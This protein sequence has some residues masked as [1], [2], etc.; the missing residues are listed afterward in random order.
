MDDPTQRPATDRA[1]GTDASLP[2]HLLAGL[3]TEAVRRALERLGEEMP[4]F[5]LEALGSASVG[6]STRVGVLIPPFVE[7]SLLVESWEQCDFLPRRFERPAYV[8]GVTTLIDVGELAGQLASDDPLVAHGWGRSDRDGRS[9]AEAMVE[10]IESATHLVLVGSARRSDSLA[11]LLD[12]LNPGAAQIDCCD[13]S[14]PDGSDPSAADLARR[15][16]LEAR[17]PRD[18]R[19]VPKW[20][21][22]LQGERDAAPGSGLLVYRRALP[23]DPT[24]FGD[25]L[26]EPPRS[27]VRGKGRVWLANEPNH[28]FAYS[29]A[30]CVHRLLPGGRWWASFGHAAWP[31]CP[32]HRR[33]LLDRWHPRFGDR[34]QELVFAA[35][36][37]DRE[38]L[39][40]DL[41]ACLVPEDQLDEALKPSAAHAP[42]IPSGP[43]T[44]LQ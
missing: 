43:R 1:T 4:L 44:G 2:V 40:S 32:T 34:G 12:L 30:G 20:M 27:L 24:R 5:P 28:S 14:S 31:S 13:G 42:A 29:C 8:A 26:A 21:E 7:P 23:F 9:V 33:R 35:V 6:R 22:V 16:L 37:L 15:V 25:W 3:P 38:R 36:D 41:D 17:R 19:V 10:Q 11:R 39:S 18:V